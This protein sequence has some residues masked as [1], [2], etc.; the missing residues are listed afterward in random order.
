MGMITNPSRRGPQTT[1]TMGPT[2]GA[3]IAGV[4]SKYEAEGIKLINER[5][6][7]NEW[8]FLYDARRDAQVAAGSVN[9]NTQANNPGNTVGAGKGNTGSSF[10]SGSFGTGGS[11]IGTGSGF[12]G[13]IG[14]GSPPGVGSPIRR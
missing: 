6:M 8:E 1:G 14:A 12:G 9:M 10:G 2:I 5:S 3:G 11:S 7:Y 4:A 13:G